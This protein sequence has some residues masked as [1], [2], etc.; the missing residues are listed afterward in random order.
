ML[1]QINDDRARS[2]WQ[3][4]FNISGDTCVHGPSCYRKRTGQ[5]CIQGMRV[6]P[7]HVIS[8]PFTTPANR[9]CEALQEHS[10]S[11]APQQAERTR[12]FLPSCSRKP[13]K[14]FI[15]LFTSPGINTLKLRSVRLILKL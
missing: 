15:L 6:Q 7:C 3:Q 10:T 5:E 14:T 11:K 8:G 9:C 13:L 4:W 1:S 12:S 2:I